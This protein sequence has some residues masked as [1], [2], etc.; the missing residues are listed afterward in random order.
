MFRAQCYSDLLDWTEDPHWM[1]CRIED[2]TFWEGMGSEDDIV[3]RPRC[4]ATWSRT[5]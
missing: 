4:A 5:G 3:K 2:D 1:A